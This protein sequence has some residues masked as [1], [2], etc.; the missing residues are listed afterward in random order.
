MLE[1]RREPNTGLCPGWEIPGARGQSLLCPDRTLED[2]S[3]LREQH[4]TDA[5]TK[6][7]SPEGALLPIIS[8]LK[9]FPLH[10]TPH[11]HTEL[12]LMER[13][14]KGGKGAIQRAHL[15]PR[16]VDNYTCTL[17]N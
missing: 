15:R 8:A 7:Q 17:H 16:H 5:E 10:L 14:K 3:T 4:F 11:W 9:L 12:L 13:V 6:A 1:A 2:A